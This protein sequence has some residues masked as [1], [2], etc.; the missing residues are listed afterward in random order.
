MKIMKT[1][2]I[3]WCVL[4]IHTYT[5]CADLCAVMCVCVCVLS[6]NQV[7]DDNDDDDDEKHHPDKDEQLQSASRTRFCVQIQ[8]VA[9]QIFAPRPS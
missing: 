6:F 4:Y 9:S 8:K 2:M 5:Y 7:S 3:I 1:I